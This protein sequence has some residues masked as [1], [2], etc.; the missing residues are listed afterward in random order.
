[1]AK[2]YIKNKVE[3]SLNTFKKRSVEKKKKK[4]SVDYA[5]AW[6]PIPASL[7]ASCVTLGK[8]LYLSVSSPIKERIIIEWL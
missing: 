6:G 4:R 5:H 8:S 7:L 1:M 3:K 2:K